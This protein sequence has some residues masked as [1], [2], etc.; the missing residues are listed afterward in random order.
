MR[1][2][3]LTG[4]LILL[5]SLGFLLAEAAVTAAYVNQ[6]REATSAE[7][8]LPFPDQLAAM[9][10]LFD[11]AGPDERSLLERA[12]SDGPVVV[13]VVPER[14]E[15]VAGPGAVRMPGLSLRLQAYA[16]ALR[17]RDLQVAIPEDQAFPLFPRLFGYTRPDS[18]RVAVSLGDGS[19]LVIQRSDSVG[20][21][22]GGLPVGLF[23]GFF[24]VTLVLLMA[25]A[26]WREVRPLRD[27]RAA[28]ERF[29]LTLAAAPVPLAG[30][31]D[32]RALIAAFNDMQARILRLDRGRT[33]MIAAI[34]H[35]IRTPLARLQM[36]LRKLEPAL[37]EAAA[38]DIAAITRVADEAGR[39]AAADLARLDDAVDL[40]ALLARR[41]EEPGVSLI[42]AAAG[43]SAVLRGNAE[44][45]S[46]AI[47]N[48]V[49]N[50]LRFGR[51]CRITLTVGPA[52][53][54]LLIDD[55]GPGI[56]AAERERLLHPFERGEVSRNA[57]T[58]GSGL[59]LA[60]AHRIVLRHG[61]SLTLGDA[62]GGGLRVRIAFPAG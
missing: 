25:A 26:V 31:P 18:V 62:P 43:R 55:D 10:T 47:D 3:G 23:S 59:G 48:L 51:L 30:A 24:G 45:L 32:L 28:A 44:L 60:L 14:P 2:I 6:R 37:Q 54:G 58:G 53:T 5:I 29:G 9:V 4:R 34:S 27:L 1:R 61:G 42:D 12:F 20:L 13:T 7:L 35:D 21:T 56:P 41:A 49:V 36:R 11:A 46:R 22:L 19:Y 16:G 50:A 52:E 40:R 38:R 39:Y 57:A 15:A 17:G 33:D 8:W